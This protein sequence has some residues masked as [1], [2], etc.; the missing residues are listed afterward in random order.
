MTPI[1]KQPLKGIIDLKMKEFSFFFFL[2]FKLLGSPQRLNFIPPL[3]V[4]ICKDLWLPLG[5]Q[6]V[7]QIHYA[8]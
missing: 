8:A 7:L 5:L 4:K 3:S 6:D 2:F 1:V